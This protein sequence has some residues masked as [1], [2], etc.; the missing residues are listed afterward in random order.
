MNSEQASSGQAR[1]A[2]QAL[3][4]AQ[5][6]RD[7]KKHGAWSMGQRID[8]RRQTSDDRGQTTDDRGQPPSPDGFGAPRRSEVRGQDRFIRKLE[9]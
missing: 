1:K 8:D 4:Q 5:D 3:R 2:R 9:N 6:K 7:E